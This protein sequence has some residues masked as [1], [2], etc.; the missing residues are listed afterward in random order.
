MVENQR[1]L[2]SFERRDDPEAD[3]L[4][5]PIEQYRAHSVHRS[6]SCDFLDDGDCTA[7]LIKMEASDEEDV[8]VVEEPET[9]YTA[10]PT[11]HK[12]NLH[13]H[14]YPNK[15][16]NLSSYKSSVLMDPDS[17]T[18][19]EDRHFRKTYSRKSRC[20][21]RDK[22]NK[23]ST[24]KDGE[25]SDVEF[26]AA[27]YRSGDSS[28]TDQAGDCASR[29]SSKTGLGSPE[30]SLEDDP[31]QSL[32]PH[33]SLIIKEE[34]SSSDDEHFETIAVK[35]KADPNLPEVNPYSTEKST[36][37]DT[38]SIINADGTVTYIKK[39]SSLEEVDGYREVGGPR[40]CSRLKK[41]SDSSSQKRPGGAEWLSDLP[42]EKSRAGWSKKHQRAA[43]A[44]NPFTCM[45]CAK[46][47][48]CNSALETHS[49]IHTGEKPFSCSKC[50]KRFMRITGLRAHEKVHTRE[51][52]FQCSEC[53]RCFSSESHFVKHQMIHTA[54]SSSPDCEGGVESVPEFADQVKVQAQEEPYPCLEG[55]ALASQGDLTRPCRTLPVEKAFSCL[56]CGKCFEL[57]SSLL[58]HQKTHREKQQL[59]CPFCSKCFPSRSHLER[60]ERIHT[61]EKPFSCSYC[62]KKFANRSSVAVHQR[63]H[64][65]EKPY[66]C[67]A[68]GRCFTDLSGLVVHKRKHERV[69]DNA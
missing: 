20:Q 50:G 48:A 47:F 3:A 65:G 68:C 69:I 66:S 17:D 12:S 39:E 41:V 52:P 1:S 15:P 13:H 56:E 6:R 58:L 38:M 5:D 26:S 43:G 42:E 45:L 59:P 64:T 18:S 61:G 2:N 22:G 21:R 32:S 60:H 44:G 51:R 29:D 30:R 9:D 11:N 40:E 35:M 53:G 54:R 23:L 28:D 55:G 10:S 49:R 14:T 25:S 4:D 37:M 24:G 62:D 67:S 33:M 63:I 16:N 8:M 36:H 31:D 27:D 34:P 57:R 7:I 46:S 19:D